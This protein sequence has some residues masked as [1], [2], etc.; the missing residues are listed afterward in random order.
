MCIRLVMGWLGGV[1]VVEVEE[2]VELFLIMMVVER[3]VGLLLGYGCFFGFGWWN[4]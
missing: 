2:E 1:L 4:R 3:W